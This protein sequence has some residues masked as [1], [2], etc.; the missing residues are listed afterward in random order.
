MAAALQI[1]VLTQRPGVPLGAF[2]DIVD[3]SGKLK[4]ADIDGVLDLQHQASCKD[5]QVYC[6][7]GP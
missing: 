3:L 5:V 7:I 2:P 4:I 6:L 1:V